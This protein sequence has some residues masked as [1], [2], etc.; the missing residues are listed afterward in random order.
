MTSKRGQRHPYRVCINF[1]P[2]ERR[3]KGGR[4]VNPYVSLSTA[5]HEARESARHGAT[6]E[7]LYLTEDNNTFLRMFVYTPDNIAAFDDDPEYVRI[8]MPDDI[9]RWYR[10]HHGAPE[11]IEGL[12]VRN[13]RTI[14]RDVPPGTSADKA[15][16]PNCP[17]DDEGNAPVD[18]AEAPDWLAAIVNEKS[19]P[20]LTGDSPTQ[21]LT[22][23][24]DMTDEELWNSPLGQRLRHYADKLL[25]A[26]AER[27]RAN[28]KRHA[29][30]VVAEGLEFGRA[31]VS[32]LGDPTSMLSDPDEP[33]RADT[34]PWANWQSAEQTGLRAALAATDGSRDAAQ[35]AAKAYIASLQGDERP[36]TDEEP[37]ETALADGDGE[38]STPTDVAGALSFLLTGNAA[39][40]RGPF[41][42]HNGDGFHDEPYVILPL[43]AMAKVLDEIPKER[44]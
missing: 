21:P 4:V 9:I 27:V 10:K 14:D 43:D 42:V 32:P 1:P 41:A 26:E 25:L 5:D 13:I 8:Y 31:V 22:A 17:Q 39:S 36:T 44:W 18:M 23:A 33:T 28:A 3:P 16:P 12:T 24:D 6:V 34:D 38:P 29:H 19:A 37:T 7:M 35:E 40:D 30:G 11:P 20:Y 2:S 15:V